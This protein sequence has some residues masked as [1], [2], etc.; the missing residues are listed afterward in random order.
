MTGRPKGSGVIPDIVRFERYYVPEPNCGCWLWTGGLQSSGYGH[1]ITYDKSE[2]SAHRFSYKTYVGPIPEGLTIDHKC[3]VK[4]CVNPEHLQVMTL[5][6]NVGRYYAEMTHCRAGHEYTLE[7]TWVSKEGYRR[8]RTCDQR[9][10]K[11]RAPE[12][13][14]Y[15]REYQRIKR[16]RLRENKELP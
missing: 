11:E 8:C 6:N 5:S 15:A 7:N 9:R 16:Q 1:F 14:V 12:H 13:R 3:N 4:I 2:R 10:D